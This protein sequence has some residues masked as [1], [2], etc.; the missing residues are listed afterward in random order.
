M[1]TSDDMGNGTEERTRDN[2]IS[3]AA[4]NIDVMMMHMGYP[5]PQRSEHIGERV[6]KMRTM[7]TTQIATRLLI[8]LPASAF[9]K[10]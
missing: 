8:E 9:H 4:M 2:L 10:V 1:H 7:T 6:K 5:A 3:F